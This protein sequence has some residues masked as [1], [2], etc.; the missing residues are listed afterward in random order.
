MQ[1][2][3]EEQKEKLKIFVIILIMGLVTCGIF[4]RFHMITDTYWNMDLG[5]EGYK[6]Y[7]LQDGR[8]I[9]YLV[10]TIG[11]VLNIPM[12]VYAVFMMIATLIFRCCSTYLIYQYL[13]KKM[14]TKNKEITLLT[15]MIMLL[16]SFIAVFNPMIVEAFAY[17][18]LV[19][20]LS[21][22]LCTKASILINENKKYKTIMALII[23]IIASI[24]YQGTINFFI[25]LSVFFFS[26][27]EKKTIKEW[28]IHLL[29]IGFICI[30][31]LVLMIAS[32]QIGAIL[33]N[34]QQG[35]LTH[36]L[37]IIQN[38]K[39]LLSISF[40]VIINTF[41]LFQKG[42]FIC[43]IWVTIIMLVLIRKEIIRKILKYMLILAIAVFSC[44]VPLFLQNGLSVSARMLM[45]VGAMIGLSILYV[46]FQNKEDK[47]YVQLILLVFS[48]IAVGVNVFNYINL[49]IMNIKTQKSEEQYCQKIRQSMEEYEKETGIKVT[50]VAIYKQKVVHLTYEDLPIN[51]FTIKAICAKWS[52]IHCL[53]YYTNKK[54]QQVA[55]DKKIYTT[56]FEAKDWNEFSKEQ[57]LFQD[58]T[59]HL[60]EI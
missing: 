53:N 19:M 3:K 42:I 8:I 45:A 52:D 29:K 23:V 17:M 50:K 57:L 43:C 7:P 12:Q 18:E 13:Y 37:N 31:A 39:S 38:V 36:E 55:K 10:L 44:T 60:C 9:N 35:R 56:Y 21:I 11:Q 54:L 22:L 40:N 28:I 47:K 24:A 49:G 33:T 51:T 58:D 27:D 46:L 6:K 4:L 15:K 1:E 5:Y 16:G 41:G 48:I 25:V 26:I 20:A 30:I 34:T 14:R 32:I 2:T 59:L